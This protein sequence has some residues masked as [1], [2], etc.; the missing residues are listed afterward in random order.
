M[1]FLSTLAESGLNYTELVTVIIFL[2]LSV[3]LLVLFP[4]FGNTIVLFI[5][6]D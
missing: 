4:L 5:F 2:I 1:A 6:Q 3:C